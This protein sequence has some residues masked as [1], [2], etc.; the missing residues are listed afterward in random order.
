M[1][2]L[3]IIRGISGSGKSTFSNLLKIAFEAQGLRAIQ[4][5]ADGYFY[6]ED[7]SYNFNV[8]E[9]NYAHEWCQDCVKLAMESNVEIILL[10]NTSTSNKEIEPYLAL[11]RQYGYTVDSIIKE[12][13]HGG[14]SI[15]NVPEITLQRQRDRLK[16]NLNLQVSYEKSYYHSRQ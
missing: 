8:K 16:A 9:L 5:E 4:C 14:V 12:N 1:K 15:H 7:G 3:I 11:A 13:L 2:K 6:D 10:S